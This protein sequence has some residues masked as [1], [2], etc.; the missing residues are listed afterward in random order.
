MKCTMLRAAMAVALALF[1]VREA[2]AIQGS[3][4]I[5]FQNE[6]ISITGQIPVANGGTG[7][8]SLTDR[9]VIIGRGTA[10]VNFASPGNAG[11]LLVS[12][13]A[14][15]NPTFTNIDLADAD[16]V[17][18]TILGFANG[19][20][21][22]SSAADDTVMVSS[23][24][25]WVA[26]P[27]TDCNAVSE[28]VTYDTATN[29]WGCNTISAG[30][31]ARTVCASTMG[32]ITQGTTVYVGFGTGGD[33]SEARAASVASSALTF[34]N[35]T[36]YG[37]VAPGASQSYTCTMG[38]GACT[39]ALTDS[40]GQIATVSGTGRTGIEAG[41]A[42]TVTDQ[43][44]YRVKIVSSSTAATGVVTACWDQTA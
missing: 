40:T 39:G 9:A 14:A 35:L 28:A 24:S 6:V 27:M 11:G 13:G 30:T 23:G 8:A 18:A 3:T 5:L 17:G 33:A 12:A 36:C 43:E 16:A 29:A 22:L 41:A 25:A 26:K 4:N 38:D 44:C 15:A 7:V 1:A 37:S 32:D 21:G 2:G 31:A 10:A 34:D 42:E 20:T 19:G